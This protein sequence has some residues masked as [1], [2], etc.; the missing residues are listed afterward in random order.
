MSSLIL[1]LFRTNGKK[2]RLEENGFRHCFANFFRKRH[3]EI[4]F[5]TAVFKAPQ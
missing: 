5:I 4:Y 1:I 2:G 3:S